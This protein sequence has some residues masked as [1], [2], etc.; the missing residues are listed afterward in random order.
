MRDIAILMVDQIFSDICILSPFGPL[1]RCCKFSAVKKCSTAS[2]LKYNWKG[3]K[4]LVNNDKVPYE[5]RNGSYLGIFDAN[6]SN[7][8]QEMA[9]FVQNYMEQ[10]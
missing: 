7:T 8:K 1:L 9:P 2:L 6:E 3:I 10:M 4:D 5:I